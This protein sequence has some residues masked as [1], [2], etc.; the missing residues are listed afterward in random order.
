MP[1]FGGIEYTILGKEYSNVAPPAHLNYFSIRNLTILLEKTG[2]NVEIT[3][4]PGELDV[5]TIRSA[6]KDGLIESTG[7]DFLDHVFLCDDEGGVRTRGLFQ[8][9]VRD[10]NNSG[11]LR[12]VAVKL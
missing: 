1:N 11:H 3:E 9:F 7:N 4:T 12:I 5:D 6:L 2:F 8:T 10:S